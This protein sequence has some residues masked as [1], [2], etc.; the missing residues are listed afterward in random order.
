MKFNVLFTI[1]LLVFASC[2]SSNT[3]DVTTNNEWELA[4]KITD[5]PQ[6]ESVAYDNA[7]N[8]LFV[9]NQNQ[10]KEVYIS[11]LSID[12]AII[13]KEWVKGLVNPKGIEIFGNT[14]YVSDETVLVEIDINTAKIIKKHEAPEAQFLNDV[15]ADNEGNI[16]VSDMLTSSIYKLDPNKNFPL[17]LFYN[18]NTKPSINNF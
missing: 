7:R 15:E 17:V 12:G 1:A 8:T 11:L 5:L 14:L 2:T 3:D 10:D 16:Y 13:E 9:S 18:Q 4:F 6:P